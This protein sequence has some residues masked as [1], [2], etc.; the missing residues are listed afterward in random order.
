[1]CIAVSAFHVTL[2]MADGQ[3]AATLWRMSVWV[4]L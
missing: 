3:K 1:M 2:A 4:Y